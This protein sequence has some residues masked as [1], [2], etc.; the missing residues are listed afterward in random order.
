[1]ARLTYFSAMLS[2][3]AEWVIVLPGLT[4]RLKPALWRAQDCVCASTVSLPGK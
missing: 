3:S 2:G 1:M 4:C